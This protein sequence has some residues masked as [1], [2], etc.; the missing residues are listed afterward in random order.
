M[1]IF[2][3]NKE[4]VIHNGAKVLDVIR[5]YYIQRNKKLPDRLPIVTDAYGNSVA[6]DG[7]LR[8]GNHLYIKTKNNRTMKT[9]STKLKVIS[10]IVLLSISLMMGCGT[11]RRVAELPKARTIEILA[12]ND[13]HAAIDNFPRFAFMT[14]SLRAIY[15]NLILVSGGDNQTGNPANDQYPEKGM[16]IIELMN[17]VSFDLSAVGNHEFDSRLAGFENIT[18]KAE[19][20]FL[21]ANIELP[22]EGNFRI[23]PYKIVETPNGLKTAFVSFLDINPNGIPDTHPDN[24]RGFKFNNPFEKAQE[25]LYLKDNSDLFIMVNHMGFEEDVKLA[26]QLPAES[27]NVIIGGHSH[28]KID[29][30]QIHN[31]IMITQAERKLKYATLIKLTVSPE[32]AVKREMEL[33]TVGNEG[34]IRTDI[35]EIVDIYNNN[36]AM[37]ETIAIAEDDFLNYEEI[38]FMMMD[39]L[40]EGA[41]ADIALINPGGVRISELPKG[42]VRTRDV[43]EMDP[44]GNETVQFNLSGHE[45]RNLFL[46]AFEIDEYLPIYPSGMTTRYLLNTDGSLKDVELF[47]TDGE[48]FEMDKMYTVVMNDYMASTYKYDHKDPGQGLFRPTAETTID[49]LKE[50]KNIPSYRGV[51]RV[52][53]VK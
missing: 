15:P 26:N 20:D 16:P 21:S 36:P 44:F 11:S 18:Q 38:G 39:A 12:V 51:Q 42:P 35:Q 22:K 43:Y 6:P 29:K 25:Y 28:T 13:M 48:L 5:A 32:G 52:E 4:V 50:L 46:S 3:N 45:I 2:I 14:D 19:F 1:K 27:V 41:G 33:L 24:V 10:G 30:D 8:E 53:I 23:E 47:T 7:E 40:R 31:G 37:T 49:Y 34:N 9:I 17:A